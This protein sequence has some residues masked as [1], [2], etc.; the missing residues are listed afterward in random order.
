MILKQPNIDHFLTLFCCPH[1]AQ[2]NF[3]HRKLFVKSIL[4]VSARKRGL[5]TIINSTCQHSLSFPYLNI[6]VV[7]VNPWHRSHC[8]RLTIPKWKS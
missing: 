6:S 7:G 5:M 1:S 8:C 4:M 3:C 2:K